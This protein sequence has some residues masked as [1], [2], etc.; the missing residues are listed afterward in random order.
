MAL[1]KK[2]KRVTATIQRIWEQPPPGAPWYYWVFVLFE[3]RGDRIQIHLKKKQ[4]KRFV[5]K[6]SEGDTGYLEYS[7]KR[8]I[9][10][11]VAS[12]EAPLFQDT[13]VKVF[14]SYS[15]QWAKDAAYI[16]QVFRAHGLDVWLDVEQL[17]VGDKLNKEIVNTITS[18]DYFIPLLSP[19]Y[20]ASPWCIKEFELAVK[21]D[22]DVLPIKVS[23]GPL[24]FPP[25]LKQLYDQQLDEPVFLDI[26][27]KDPSARLKELA[28][29]IL[30]GLE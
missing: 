3:S 21:E 27:G 18:S 17:R 25:H 13:G 24:A 29:Q 19:E 16:A 20:F 9:S 2:K 28:A 30:E 5:K 8:M 23:E 26:R 7:G 10:W 15:H 1:F 11:Q 6:Y 12:E 22:M 4:A 14:M